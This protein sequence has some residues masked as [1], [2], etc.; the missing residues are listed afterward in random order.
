MLK[1]IGA[2]LDAL[3]DEIVPQDIRRSTPV[4]LR[5]RLRFGYPSGCG[6][7]AKNQIFAATSAGYHDTITPPVVRNVF[8][9]PGWYAYAYQAE[10][11]RAARVVPEF[12]DDGQ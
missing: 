1:A 8:E 4:N 11:A 3:M 9:N 6:I 5:S 12:P 10:I 7:A 2:S